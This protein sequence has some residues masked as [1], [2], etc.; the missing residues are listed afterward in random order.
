L[1]P[2]PT[3]NH[4]QW[5]IPTGGSTSALSRRNNKNVLTEGTQEPWR[6][7]GFVALLCLPKSCGMIGREAWTFGGE[8]FGWGGWTR[9][10]TVLINSEVPYQLDHP[11]AVSQRPVESFKDNRCTPNAQARREDFYFVDSVG[12]PASVQERQPPSIE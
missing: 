12:K 4:T 3:P 8:G 11:P 9:T 5:T 2:P 6:H 7:S 10:N 1:L